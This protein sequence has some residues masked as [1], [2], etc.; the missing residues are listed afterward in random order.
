MS[1]SQSQSLA[2]GT[3][4]RDPRTEF[5]LLLA[6]IIWAANYPLA[7]F[8]LEGLDAFIFNGVRFIAATIVLGVPFLRHAQWKPIASR[9]LP[10]FLR[11]GVLASILYQILFIVGLRMTTAGNSAVLLSTSPLWTLFL[12]AR[13]HREPVEPRM[14]VGMILSLAGI[15]MIIIGS[16]KKLAFGGMDIAGD[17]V[18][19]VAAALWG[20]NTNLQKPLL[21]RYSPLQ[22]SFVFCLIGAIGLTVVAVPSAASISWSAVPS[23]AW[24]AAVLSGTFSIGIG[25]AIW[26]LGVQRF[27]PGRT[28]N[29]NN[30]IPVLAILISYLTLH[31]ELLAIQFIGAAVTIL[32]VW[33]VRR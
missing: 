9:D 3:P 2:A 21:V 17:L 13:I 22:L 19:L 26:S 27:G 4:H 29:F 31:E 15:V 10:G 24:I 1:P 23:A 32:G 16:G 28:A 8:G 18:M 11:A 30:L 7:K 25:N 5:L 20:L 33:V 14:W 6:I 12:S